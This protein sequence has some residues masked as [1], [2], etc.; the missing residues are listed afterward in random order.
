MYD[1]AGEYV[2]REENIHLLSKCLETASGILLLIDPLQFPR[3]RQEVSR[4]RPGI[5]T[6]GAMDQ[7]E[8]MERLAE[9]LRERAGMKR[10]ATPLAVALSKIDLLEG[11]F[12]E[13]SAV[14]GTAS[15]Q[16]FYDDIDG[17]NVHEEIRALLDQWDG[18]ELSDELAAT[19][20]PTATSG[21]RPSATSRRRTSACATRAST[22]TVWKTLCCGFSPSTGP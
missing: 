15:H 9:L 10:L 20:P 4:T 21:C 18:P 1:S 7:K 11:M 3:I 14:F 19:S 17:Q 12:G 2:L 22:R 13:D 8:V 5:R 6:E 16:G